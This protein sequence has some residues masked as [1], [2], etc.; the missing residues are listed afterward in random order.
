ME[1]W[2][3]L[4]GQFC[5]HEL[6]HLWSS[7]LWAFGSLLQFKLLPLPRCT[8]CFQ[9]ITAATGWLK[10]SSTKHWWNIMNVKLLRL[11]VYKAFCNSWL[12]GGVPC[13]SV[14]SK[15]RSVH[16]Q[17]TLGQPVVH[18]LLKINSQP[19]YVGVIVQLHFPGSSLG[20]LQSN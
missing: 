16:A 4:M 19:S 20:R 6:S 1:Q 5:L 3:T 7:F 12:M 8:A 11:S 17:I 9:L 15:Q 14:K 10:L 18:M 13:L 2:W